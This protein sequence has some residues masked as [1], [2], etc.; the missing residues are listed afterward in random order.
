MI[1]EDTKTIRK[2]MWQYF[3]TLVGFTVSVVAIVAFALLIGCGTLH[4]PGVQAAA[5]LND[6]LYRGPVGAI[7]EEFEDPSRASPTMALGTAVFRMGRG[8][9]NLL[10][11]S[12]I[13]LAPVPLPLPCEYSWWWPY[14]YWQCQHYYKTHGGYFLGDGPQEPNDRWDLFGKSAYPDCGWSKRWTESYPTCR[15]PDEI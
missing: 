12:G 4:A 1:E 9:G 10:W 14:N 13:S 3:A 11:A 2:L 15:N 5:G 7:V 8:L 6:I